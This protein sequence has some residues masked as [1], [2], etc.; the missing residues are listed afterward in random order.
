MPDHYFRPSLFCTILTKT[1]RPFCYPHSLIRLLEH[2][3]GPNTHLSLIVVYGVILLWRDKVWLLLLR[4]AWIVLIVHHLLLWLGCHVP[5]LR[6]HHAHLLLLKV[7]CLHIGARHALILQV[8][9]GLVLVIVA[10]HQVASASIPEILEL[11]VCDVH[12]KIQN[13]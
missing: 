1:T 7:S 3:R 4:R 2:D 12:Q 13:D 10:F 9:S 11:D 5:R 8:L 6:L